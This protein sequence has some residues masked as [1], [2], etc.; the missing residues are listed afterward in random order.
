MGRERRGPD[1]SSIYVTGIFVRSL[2]PISGQSD[3][4]I[5]PINFRTRVSRK[6]MKDDGGINFGNFWDL[7]WRRNSIGIE[8]V[9]WACVEAVDH[10][11]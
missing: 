7:A 5:Y 1:A 4:P 2:D 8:R 6:T 10:K 9:R 3:L 11:S